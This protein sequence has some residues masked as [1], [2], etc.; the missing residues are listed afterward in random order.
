[1]TS[2]TLALRLKSKKHH[3]PEQTVKKLCDA[4]VV[5]NAEKDQAAVLLKKLEDENKRLRELVL[6]ALL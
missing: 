5:L 1:V 2:L 4:D 6:C 3:S